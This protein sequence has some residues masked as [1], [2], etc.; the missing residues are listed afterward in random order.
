MTSIPFF[1]FTYFTEALIVFSY[2]KSLYKTKKN[3]FITFLFIM[4]I[5]ELLLLIFKILLNNE[6][7]NIVAIILLIGL[8]S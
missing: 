2:V 8:I 6:I 5:Y 3:P 7:L 4:I 1:V